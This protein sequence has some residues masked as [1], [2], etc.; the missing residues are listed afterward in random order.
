M[1]SSAFSS[2]PAN[3]MS[4]DVLTSKI[5]SISKKAHL[6]AP[7]QLPAN[8]LQGEAE[9]WGDFYGCSQR[10]RAWFTTTVIWT[11]LMF[12][13]GGAQISISGLKTEVSGDG[14]LAEKRRKMRTLLTSI[15]QAFPQQAV[16]VWGRAN[17]LNFSVLH[18]NKI[19]R[20]TQRSIR[21]EL[22]PHSVLS[23]QFTGWLW[24]VKRYRVEILEEAAN[25]HFLPERCITLRPWLF[26]QQAS[27]YERG[28]VLDVISNRT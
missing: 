12:Y 6:K 19:L 17:K 1:R 18:K 11:W 25:D 28:G 16:I 4:V 5:S 26:P 22:P 9:K 8:K 23:I 13:S 21:R 15:I 3:N 27:F 24:R 14:F 2:I 10:T 7:C 20:G